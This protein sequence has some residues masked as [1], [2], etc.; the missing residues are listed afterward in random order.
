MA[1]SELPVKQTSDS[2]QLGRS[3]IE[4]PV[5][6]PSAN[7]TA[8]SRTPGDSLVKRPPGVMTQGWPPSSPITS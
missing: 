1:D 7:S 2:P 4:H 6:V 8:S 3:Q 5:A